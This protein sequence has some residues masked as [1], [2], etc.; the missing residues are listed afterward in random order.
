M[1]GT[2]LENIANTF[3][4]E[5]KVEKFSRIATIFQRDLEVT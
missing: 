3:Q 5:E 4:S 1:T 2:V